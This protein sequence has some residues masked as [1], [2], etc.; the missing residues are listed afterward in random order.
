MLCHYFEDQNIF[1]LLGYEVIHVDLMDGH[2]IVRYTES[3]IESTIP[4]G[5]L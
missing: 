1:I 2:F 5:Q 4:I 3:I